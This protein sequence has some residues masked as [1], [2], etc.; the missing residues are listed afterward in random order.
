MKFSHVFLV[1]KSAMMKPASGSVGC[2]SDWRAG[3]EFDPRRGRQHSFVEI[4]H[5]YFLRSYPSADSGRAVVSFWQENQ[6]S[7]CILKLGL[8]LFCFL[9]FVPPVYR[10][11]SILGVRDKF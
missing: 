11:S 9:S 7:H 6:G 2:A 3:R 10:D 8:N 1:M 5:E 4:D